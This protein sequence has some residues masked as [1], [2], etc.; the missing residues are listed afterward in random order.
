MSESPLRIL[1]VYKDVYPTVPGGI[2]RHIDTLRRSVPDVVS[3]VIVCS[4]STRTTV[5]S[6]TG[7]VEVSVGELGRVLSTPVAPTL[8]LWLRRIP[9][10]VVHMHMPNPAGEL[11]VLLALPDPPLVISYHADIVRQARLL[12]VYAPLVR[13]CLR[14]SAAIVC[15]SAGIVGSSPF[16]G[17]FA[18]K[19]E[20]IPYA[21]DLDFFDPDM[22]DVAQVAAVR[23]RI[24]TPLVVATGRLVYYKGFERLIELAS[25]IAGSL[26]IV[27]GGP[28]EADLRRKAREHSNVTL[29]GPVS[30]NDLRTYL[31]AADCFVLGSTSHAE[32]FGIATVEAQAMGVPAVVTNVGTGTHEAIRDGVTGHVVPSDDPRQL[33]AAVNAILL[34]DRRR[35]QM[36]VAA[37]DW[38]C[39]RFALVDA[40]HAHARLYQRV[41]A[42]AV[43][44]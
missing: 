30:D 24:G 20:R 27:G 6:V 11:A 5:R 2:E 31:A 22:V 14:R 28:L 21:V 33:V 26:V 1:H 37:R 3:N 23:A 9:T 15:G 13:R 8:A 44:R 7:G 32:S 39:E 17:S 36:A 42:S 38:A 16:L 18:D 43:K 40:A 35:A 25:E 10:D 19:I 41:A 4:R 34:D 12:P 29:T